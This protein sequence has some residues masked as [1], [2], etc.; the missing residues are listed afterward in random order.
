MLEIAI[1]L[2]E[3]TVGATGAHGGAG[4]MEI[5]QRAIA[6][7]KLMITFFEVGRAAPTARFTR[8]DLDDI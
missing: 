3:V 8:V 2:P 4:P 5:A 6:I 7:I 1:I